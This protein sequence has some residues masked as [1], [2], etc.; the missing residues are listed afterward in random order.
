MFSGPTIIPTWV[1]AAFVASVPLQPV[2]IPTAT[3]VVAAA[4]RR[5]RNRDCLPSPFMAECPQ[6]CRPMWAEWF[7]LNVAAAVVVAVAAARF[8]SR[9]TLRLPGEADRE[10]APDE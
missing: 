9:P 10:S 7:P 3:S 5:L 1:V 4:R 8:H 2:S 6:L